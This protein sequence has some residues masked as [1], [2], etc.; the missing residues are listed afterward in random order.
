MT[1]L[2]SKALGFIPSRTMRE[3]LTA[4]HNKGEFSFSAEDVLSLAYNSD[5]S[6][7]ERFDRIRE[8][9]ALIRDK[10][11]Y[12]QICDA[13][14]LLESDFSENG[15]YL[16]TKE[17]IYSD[18]DDDPEPIATEEL[19]FRSVEEA[20]A[21]VAENRR[22]CVCC[23]LMRG[24]EILLDM[25]DIDNEYVSSF[26]TSRCKEEFALWYDDLNAADRMLN[27]YVYIPNPFEPGD[28]VC[29]YD[30]PDEKYII[31]DAV[32]PCQEDYNGLLD[33]IDEAAMVVPYSIRE[34]ATPEKIKRH[35][36]RLP[37]ERNDGNGIPVD[38]ISQ[39]HDH[40]ITLFLELVEKAV[41]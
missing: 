23:K 29:C 19:I 13:A 2:F 37:Q 35:Y 5:K 6:F 21:Y 27:A 39:H 24:E 11:S 36:E 28:T 1:D 20:A 3:H 14:A 18:N 16:Y 7:K 31:I 32:P 40:I 4:L 25:V 33:H 38:E 34:H 10:A 15:L 41:R 26:H 22:G 8:L 17:D 30:D 12:R 9:E